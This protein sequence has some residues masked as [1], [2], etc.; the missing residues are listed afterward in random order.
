M[1][2]QNN[3]PTVDDIRRQFLALKTE[4][5][6]LRNRTIEIMNASFIADKPVIF[7]RV[8]QDYVRREHDW[9]ISESLFI[10]D[11]EGKIPK[12]WQDIASEDG[13]I[14]SNYGWCLFSQDN[15][16]QWRRAMEALE[17]DLFTRQAVM[18]YNRPTMHY[19]AFD[20]E[21]KD[22][23][24]TYA[25]QVLIREGQVHYF[26][27]M[28]SSD[29]IFGYKNDYAWHSWVQRQVVWRLTKDFPE[30]KVGKLFWNAGSF[31][32][33]EDKLRLVE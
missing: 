5:K 9:Y 23:I 3:L 22:F 4:N 8:D 20:N 6:L 13:K 2:F 7:G 14:N 25:A 31:H 19:D 28:R 11:I 26:V 1:S 16:F 21:M 33:Y 15:G 17:K 10:K 29:A 12:I 27:Y 24:C 30:L 32:I 18:I